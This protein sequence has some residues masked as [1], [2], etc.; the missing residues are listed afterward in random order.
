MADKN[1]QP[2]ETAPKDGT[3]LLLLIA[4]SDDRENELE[5]SAE[6]TR[7][8]GFNNLFNDGEDV[9]KFAGWCWSNDHFTEGKGA[10][11]GWQQMPAVAEVEK[12]PH[13][14][15]TDDGRIIALPTWERDNE[16]T[17]NRLL[18]A[19]IEVPPEE[20]AK[21]TDDQVRDTDVWTCSVHLHASDNDDIKVPPKPA[22][23]PEPTQRQPSVPGTI[24]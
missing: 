7:T 22:H 1:W 5:D 20:I 23:L 14:D 9:W 11:C 13:F 10:P 18:M 16:V 17:S 6:P 2:M 15:I 19:S 8:I 21:W 24:I 4:P 12:P 3:L